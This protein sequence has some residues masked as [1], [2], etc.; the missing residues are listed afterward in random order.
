[1]GARGSKPTNTTQTNIRANTTRTNTRVNTTRKN[2]PNN[3]RRNKTRVNKSANV[4]PKPIAPTPICGHPIWPSYPYGTPETDCKQCPGPDPEQKEPRRKVPQKCLEQW[5][6]DIFLQEGIVRSRAKAAEAAVRKQARAATAIAR[7]RVKASESKDP[8]PFNHPTITWKRI[9]ETAEGS[10]DTW[11][12]ILFFTTSS[13][14]EYAIMDVKAIQDMTQNGKQTHPFLRFFEENKD[15]LMGFCNLVYDTNVTQHHLEVDK[16]DPYLIL[17][18][19][20]TNMG[21]SIEVVGF[22]TVE[23]LDDGIYIGDLCVGPKRGGIGRNILEQMKAFANYRGFDYVK[24][25][26]AS[27]TEP[28]YE[29]LGF[30]TN[31]KNDRYHI[32]YPKHGGRRTV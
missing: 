31:A 26:P 15:K 23:L 1:M 27:N 16:L 8:L 28:F 17:H 2:V 19:V 6:Q 14:E 22:M 25:E 21:E 11:H 4:V 7:S 3:A 5:E 9:Q 18:R 10:R 13:N 12:P 32:W 30:R 20:S 24:L 29:K